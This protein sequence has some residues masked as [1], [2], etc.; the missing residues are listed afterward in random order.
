MKTCTGFVTRV[1]SMRCECKPNLWMR[2]K[3]VLRKTG[4]CLPCEARK[5]LATHKKNAKQKRIARTKQF[6]LPHV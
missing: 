4:D 5:V 6:E 3:P 2:G 1:A